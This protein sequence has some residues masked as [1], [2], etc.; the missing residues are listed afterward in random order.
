MHT[1]ARTKLV[2]K[3]VS[4]EGQVDL[5]ALQQIVIALA[6]HACPCMKQG[7]QARGADQRWLVLVHASCDQIVWRCK[8]VAVRPRLSQ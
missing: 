5:N 8:D 3:Q 6:L 7:Y 2:G 4:Q 1:Q